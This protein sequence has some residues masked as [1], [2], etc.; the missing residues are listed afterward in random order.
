MFRIWAKNRRFVASVTSF[1]CLP[2][3]FFV[4][5]SHSGGGDKT[6]RA[7]ADETDMSSGTAAEPAELTGDT[8]IISIIADAEFK[9]GFICGGAAHEDGIV[10]ELVSPVSTGDRPS[11]KIAQ[12]ACKYD[13]TKGEH[14]ADDGGYS[15]VTESQKVAVSWRESAPLLTL[16]LKASEEYDSP[17]TAGQAWPHLLIEQTGLSDRCP[18]LDKVENLNLILET[19]VLYC[20]SYHTDKA[21]PGL[22]AAQI[23]LFF[24][25]QSN[26]TNDM[27]WFGVPVFDN[28]KKLV[29]EYMAED[30]GKEDAS[31]KFIYTVAQKEFT[32]MSARDFTKIRYEEDLLPYIKKGLDHAYKAGYLN[33]DNLADYTL[34]TCNLGYEMPGIYDSAFE[35]Y[36][37]TLDAVLK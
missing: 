33:S 18:K 32:R 31:H 36:Q 14:I 21:D 2:L 24:T 1:V 25:V 4:S 8:N 9:N 19:R 37:F 26:E 12:W 3:I 23:T 17:R 16:E 30:G 35:I 29:P 15:Y 11:W 13:I 34:T 28:R 10:G 27:Y 7:A 6:D 20:E 22:H 5:C